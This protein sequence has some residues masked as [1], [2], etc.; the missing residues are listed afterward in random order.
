MGVEIKGKFKSLS[1][2]NCNKTSV[3]FDDLIS[4]VEVNN[5]KSVKMQ[6]LGQCPS[7]CID[8]TDGCQVWLSAKSLDCGFTC[9]KISEVNVSWPDPGSADPENPDA[10]DTVRKVVTANVSD[11][12]SEC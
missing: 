8:K 3:S 4:M 10:I 2:V 1:V 12:Y 7:F 9:A 11:L 6:A 5:C